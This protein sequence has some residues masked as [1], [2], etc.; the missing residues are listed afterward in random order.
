MLKLKELTLFPNKCQFIILYLL[1]Q[2]QLNKIA[3]Y[4]APTADLGS[5]SAEEFSLF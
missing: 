5:Y 1:R 2:S 4:Q 3:A